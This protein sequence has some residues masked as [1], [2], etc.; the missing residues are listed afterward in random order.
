MTFPRSAATRGRN[1]RQP[2]S[3]LILM[4]A[5]AASN[6][7]ANQATRETRM[8]APRQLFET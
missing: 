2:K 8:Q 6:A 1:P 5:F 7:A 4:M 3:K